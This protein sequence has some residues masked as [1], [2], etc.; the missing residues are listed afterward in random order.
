[1][2]E[3]WEKDKPLRG[4][5]K[6]TETIEILTEFDVIMKKVNPDH[7]NLIKAKDVLGLEHAVEGNAITVCRDELDDLK[8]VWETMMKLH[9][10][11]EDVKDTVFSSARRYGQSSTCTR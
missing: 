2:V 7:E 9:S 11:L 10:T 8:K 1:M 4:N 6:P 3:S 5:I